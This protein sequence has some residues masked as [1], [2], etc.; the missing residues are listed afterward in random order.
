MRSRTPFV[1]PFPPIT[2]TR[3]VNGMEPCSAEDYEKL[4]HVKRERGGASDADRV[5]CR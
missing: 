1:G 2:E 5:D 3:A 4:P